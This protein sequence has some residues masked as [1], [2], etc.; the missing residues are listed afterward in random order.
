M[1][2]NILIPYRPTTIY[3]RKLKLPVI[4]NNDM[5][6]VI[7]KSKFNNE[8]EILEIYYKNSKK[9]KRNDA[10]NAIIF[11]PFREPMLENCIKAIRKNSVFNHKVIVTTEPDV[12]FNEKF[13]QYL[14]KKYG[15]VIFFAQATTPNN[16]II[17]QCNGLREALQ[18]VPDNE[19]TCYAYNV[20]VICGKYWDKRVEEAYNTYGD[21]KVYVPMWVEPRTDSYGIANGNIF[22]DKFKECQLKEPLT[23]ESIWG[24]WRS[25][26]CHSLTMKFPMKEYIEEKDL[27]NWSKICNSANK[28]NVV[29]KCGV[30]DYAYYCC[31]IARSKIFKNASK[32]LLEESISDLLF[33][34][35]LN[36]DK[37]AVTKAH[38]FHLHHKVMLDDIEVEREDRVCS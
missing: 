26:C 10:N 16:R 32:Y 30:R 18:T 4:Q 20:D 9:F 22:G 8:E 27:D 19:Y 36:T 11:S 29:E 34:N 28:E 24:V 12:I 25:R 2:F 7:D 14:N 17:A 38:V 33:D 31:M 3:T 23:A 13:K 21:D 5:L 1:K 15:D 6:W 37:V 35:N